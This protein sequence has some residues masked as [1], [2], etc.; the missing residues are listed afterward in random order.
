ML[1]RMEEFLSNVKI[2]SYKT[3][4]SHVMVTMSGDFS[5]SNIFAMLMGGST[6]CLRA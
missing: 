1:A 2:Q 4:G 5:V 3:K 6:P